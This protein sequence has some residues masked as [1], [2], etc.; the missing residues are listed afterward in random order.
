MKRFLAMLLV[1]SVFSVFLISSNTMVFAADSP[2][3]TNDTENT[4]SADNSETVDDMESSETTES[5]WEYEPKMSN[6]AGIA[7]GS[8]VSVGDKI[9]F[10]GGI[11]DGETT[12]ELNIYDTKSKSWSL[13]TPFKTARAVHIS[14]AYNNKIYIMG[15]AVGNGIT[16]SVE[17]YDIKTDTWTQGKNMLYSEAHICGVLVGNKIYVLS[18]NNKNNS[19]VQIY[20]IEN[21][22]WSYGTNFPEYLYQP[23]AAAIG[24]KIYVV[25]RN[26]Q[27][28]EKPIYIYDTATDSWSTTGKLLNSYDDANCVAVGNKIYVAPLEDYKTGGDSN[29]TMIYDVTTNTWTQGPNLNEPRT[30]RMIVLVGNKIYVLGGVA[31]VSKFTV[32]SLVVDAPNDDTTDNKLSVLLNQGE[33]VK[34]SVTG[35]PSDNSKYTWTSSDDTVATVDENGVVTAVNT[36][37]AN[38]YAENTES[39]FKEYIPVVVVGRNGRRNKACRKS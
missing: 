23:R 33:S 13:G 6:Y 8:A 35:T 3:S 1:L 16:T 5:A 11:L 18:Y 31:N 19:N 7:A 12:N 9:Y 24:D 36:G 10:T 38:I 15:G 25:T 4:S 2:E 14:I 29:K 27:N 30:T 28:N 32:E 22:T 37:K 21:N 34:L 26:G 39:K 17:I 20:D